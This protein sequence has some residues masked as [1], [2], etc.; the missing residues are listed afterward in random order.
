MSDASGDDEK[1]FVERSK[2]PTQHQHVEQ[3]RNPVMTLIS[4]AMGT[5]N[6][7]SI[8]PPAA[9]RR[10]SKLRILVVD[11]ALSILK[12]VRRYLE[13]EGH[14]VETAKNGFVALERMKKAIAEDVD[15]S[16]S[17]DLVLM[18]IQMP[19]M[20]KYGLYCSIIRIFLC[21]TLWFSSSSVMLTDLATTKRS[22]YSISLSFCFGRWH[23]GRAS[24]PRTR[25]ASAEN[26]HRRGTQETC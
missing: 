12:V 17:L 25:V 15:E 16:T 22:S 23:R 7:V 24:F 4:C 1:S 18:D 10:H 19:V 11:D 20:G 2:Y 5:L 3:K 21:T 8:S 13:S 26:C 6:N 9:M 14:H